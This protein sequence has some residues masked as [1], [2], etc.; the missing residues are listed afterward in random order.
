MKS[1]LVP[2][3]STENGI[4]NLKYAIHFA[5]MSGA[6]VYL[7]NLYKEFSKVGQLAKVNQ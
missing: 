4:N 6:K 3:S 7:I 1:I 5:S 2:V